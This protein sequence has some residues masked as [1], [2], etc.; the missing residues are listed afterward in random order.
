MELFEGLCGEQH[1]TEEIESISV[2]VLHRV[3]RNVLYHLDLC[4]GAFGDHFQH[5]S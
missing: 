5:L 3:F 1:I 2:A 4:E